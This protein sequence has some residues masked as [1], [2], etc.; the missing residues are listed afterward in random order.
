MDTIKA[1]TR[2]APDGLLQVAVPE[3]FSNQELEVVLVL[4][5]RLPSDEVHPGYP[6]EYFARIDAIQAD[7]VMER[8]T[9]QPERPP[10]VEPP[11]FSL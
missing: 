3:Y 8:G 2:V 1:V 4:Q 11:A 9:L 10:I 7:D 5:T 6:P